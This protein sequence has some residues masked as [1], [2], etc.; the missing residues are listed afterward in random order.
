ML[1]RER[2]KHEVFQVWGIIS[3]KWGGM[4]KWNC[5]AEQWE[6]QSTKSVIFIMLY[7]SLAWWV[8]YNSETCLCNF[9]LTSMTLMTRYTVMICKCTLSLQISSLSSSYLCTSP[10]VYIIS[11]LNSSCPKQFSTQISALFILPI[12]ISICLY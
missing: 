7:F 2:K 6:V 10:P 9:S 11:T 3:S 8:I 5:Y 4:K 12:Q 1:D